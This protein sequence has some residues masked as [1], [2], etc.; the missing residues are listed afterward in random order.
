M[1][2]V[3]DASTGCLV[4]RAA[5]RSCRRFPGLGASADEPGP[6]ESKI[7][8]NRCEL[9]GAG[10]RLATQRERAN[11]LPLSPQ[12]PDIRF[13]PARLDADKALLA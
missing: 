3:G 11:A 13:C 5:Q 4:R 6:A 12:Q 1:F 8:F 7:L 10:E 9:T 2:H